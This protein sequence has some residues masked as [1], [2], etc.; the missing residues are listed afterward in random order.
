MGANDGVDAAI[1]SI[2]GIADQKA[3]TNGYKEL[4]DQSLADEEKLKAIVSHL[5]DDGVLLV[6]S[7]AVMTHLASALQQIDPEKFKWKMDFIRFCLIKIKPQLISYEEVDVI[8]RE[9]LADLYVDEEE[10]IEAAKALAAINLESSAR[11]YTDVQKAEKYVKIA[12][13]YLEEDETVDAENF[14]NRASRFIHSVEDWTL[15]LRYQVSYARILDSKRKF[16]DA[17]LRYYEFSQTKP[18]EVDPDNL[19]E[20]LKKGVTCAILASAGPQRSR[21]LGT[22]YKD[23]RVKNS[24]YF[25]ILEKMYTEQ[26]IRRPELVQFEQS[27]LP[28]QKAVLANGFTVLENAFLEHNLLAASRVYTSIALEELGK[29]LE[30]DAA[31]AE[32]VA[33]TMICEERMKGTIDQFSGFLEFESAGDEVLP[34]F[35]TQISSICFNV[36]QVA[37][38]IEQLY[39]QLLPA[40]SNINNS[41]SA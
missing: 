25:P 12:E 15:K 26:L 41:I 28:H 32:R 23:E 36:N 19:L 8:F 4:V 22:L 11:Q 24:E 5:L 37:E 16:L 27:L 40:A 33:A 14:I 38:K 35:D 34:A 31:N 1:R 21:L 29:L 7:R 3:K 18:D 17:A 20:L 6:I 30:I 13:L 10:Y 39:P 2:A 9:S